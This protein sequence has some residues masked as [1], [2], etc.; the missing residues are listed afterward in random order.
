M[1]NYIDKNGKISRL[2]E[3]SFSES[4]SNTINDENIDHDAQNK[5]KKV[6]ENL[7]TKNKNEIPLAIYE[8]KEPE[9]VYSE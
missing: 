2:Y 6:K 9:K 1:I 8:I 7:R 3:K 5:A 4:D